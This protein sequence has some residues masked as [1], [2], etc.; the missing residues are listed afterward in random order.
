MK[1]VFKVL[2]LTALVAVLA[3]ACNVSLQA[4]Q[5]EITKTQ[6]RLRLAPSLNAGTLV[7]NHGYNIHPYKGQLLPYLGTSG[8]FYN[9]SYKGHSVYVHNSCSRYVGDSNNLRYVVVNGVDVNLRLGPSVN[10]GRLI[11][12]GVVAHPYKGQRLP[13]LGSSGNFYKVNY[14]GNYVFISKDFSYLE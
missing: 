5:V 12:N 8:E 7:D 9:V 1:Q 13:Y 11:I 6:V 2:R 14:A 10:S 4:Q 3:L